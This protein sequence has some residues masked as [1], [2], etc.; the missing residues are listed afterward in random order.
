MTE[1]SSGF[2]NKSFSSSTVD[3]W[4]SDC[5]LSCSLTSAQFGFG[6]LSKQRIRYIFVNWRYDH[7]VGWNLKKSVQC[8]PNK[9]AWS[10]S[11]NHFSALFCHFQPIVNWCLKLQTTIWIIIKLFDIFYVLRHLDE[12]KL[13]DNLQFT[14]RGCSK[15]RL[16]IKEII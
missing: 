3:N 9:Q 10:I 4:P 15:W 13:D 5:N 7:M 12:S 2:S 14:C 1:S 16:F 6:Q 8:L 11:W